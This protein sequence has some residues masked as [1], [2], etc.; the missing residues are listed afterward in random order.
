[1]A[2]ALKSLASD[3]LDLVM[4]DINLPDS[5]GLATIATLRCATDHPIIALLGKQDA[6]LVGQLRESGARHVLH[7]NHLSVQELERLLRLAAVQV[8]TGGALRESEERFR[9]SFE[10]AGVGK[11]IR[12]L[13][14]RWLRVNQK[15]CDILGYPREELIT[16]TS[17]ELTPPEDRAAAIDHD[18]RIRMGEIST[19]TREKRYLRKDGT[20]VWANLVD[21]VVKGA[22]GK[23]S[24]VVSIVHDI[25]D[26][27]H[28]EKQLRDSEARFRSLTEM[29]SDFYWETDT[30]HLLTQMV[31]GGRYPYQRVHSPGSQLGKTRWALPSSRP[32]A[33]GWDAHKA[34]LEAHRPFHDFYIARF[35]TEGLER[36]L[37]ISGDPIFDD[38]GRFTGYRGVGRNIT[39]QRRAEERQAA[40]ARQQELI[41]EFGRNALGLHEVQALLAD[42]VLSSNRG[43]SADAVAYYALT[44]DGDKVIMRASVGCARNGGEFLTTTHDAIGHTLKSGEASAQDSQDHPNLPFPCDWARDLQSSVTVPV[45]GEL[46]TCGV[47]CALSA[48][49]NAYGDAEA[50][51]LGAMA[52]VLSAALQRIESEQRLAHLAQFDNLTGLPNRALLLDRFGQ[53]VAQA[54]RHGFLLGVMFVDLDHFK[55]VNDTLGHA[56]GDELLKETARRLLECTRSGDTVARISG[57]EFVVILGELVHAEHAAIAAQKIIK[58]IATPFSIAAQESFVSASVGIAVY[59]G[60]GDDAEALLGAAD[61]AMY[62][63]KESG[64]NRYCY[65]TAGITQSTRARLQLSGELRRALERQEFRLFYQPKVALN[66]KTVKGVEALLRWTHPERGLVSPAEFIPALEE[67]GL[68]VAVGEWVLRQAC[69]D[70]KAWRAAGCKPVPVAV[71][72]SARQFQHRDLDRRIL[73]II[74]ESGIE[75]TLIEL[76]ITESH[77][78]QDPEHAIRVVNA[79]NQAGVRFAIDD[80]G[81]GYSS[82]SYLTRFPVSA[83][84]IDRSFMKDIQSDTHNAVI[85]RTIIEM[86][87]TLGF[88]VVAEGVETE[89]QSAFLNQLDCEQAQGFLFARPMPGEQFAAMLPRAEETSSEGLR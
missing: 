80:F 75:P 77:L 26:G 14:G 10:V 60:D 32:D 19:Y 12:G 64:R 55:L 57:D 2:D 58:R 50:G 76:E 23:P 25:T 69:A 41:A 82:L 59:P 21:N 29:S 74:G 5:R 1:M 35:D 27:K 16:R 28:A 45:R 83:L 53:M 78:M 49:R 33:A 65:F 31:F 8:Q 47:L 30:E 87:H 48:R 20:I 66:N 43:L 18:Q 73:G 52:S 39:E 44:S 24:Y 85:V 72:L 34:T 15:L 38:D 88:I 54:K 7:K 22:D 37:V 40:H 62:R 81:T 56:A 13:D 46:R 86:A 84:K 63:A 17:I 9:A 3:D 42:A 71:N 89:N 68:I 51:F 11:A 36:H 61:A 6:E 70:I 79:L 67:T 4:T